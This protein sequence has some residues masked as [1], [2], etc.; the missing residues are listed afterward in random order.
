MRY[1]QGEKLEIIRLVEGSDLPIRTTLSRLGVSRASFYRWYRSYVKH[2]AD[3]LAPKPSTRR[4]FWNR[5]PDP[6]RE[7]VVE[8]ALEKPE[9]SARELAFWISDNKGFFISESSVYRILKTYDLVTS[10]AYIVVSAADEFKHKTR[11]VHE[12][13][14]T[15]FTYFKIVGWGWYYL[16]TVLDDFSRY[17][18][19]W[20]LQIFDERRGRAGDAGPGPV[21]GRSGPGPGPVSPAV[22]VKQRSLLRVEGSADV[23]GRPRA[24]PTRA[25]LRT[26]RRLKARSNATTGR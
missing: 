17:I 23:S 2:G 22:V 4:Q 15:D 12:M 8:I 19:S 5:I 13:W 25:A 3:G 11:R 16:S 14:Q 24:C 18:I 21:C 6:E 9:M 20:S 1:T 10:P 26:I 7:R